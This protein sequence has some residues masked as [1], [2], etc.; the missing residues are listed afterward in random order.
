[1]TLLFLVFAACIGGTLIGVFVAD[2]FGWVS[3]DNQT[4]ALILRVSTLAAGLFIRSERPRLWCGA[5]RHVITDDDL[6]RLAESGPCP[7]CG[8]PGPITSRR[9]GPPAPAAGDDELA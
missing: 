2:W 6:G 8:K 7:E 9:P 4:V 5:R 3:E 1:M